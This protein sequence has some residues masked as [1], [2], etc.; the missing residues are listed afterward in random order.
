MHTK[1]WRPAAVAALAVAVTVVLAGLTPPARAA[2]G[3]TRSPASAAIPALAHVQLCA[4]R[5]A[6][7]AARLVVALHGCTQSAPT[8]TATPAGRSS[9]TDTAAPWCC[10]SR[11]ANNPLSCFNWFAAG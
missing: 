10:R 11:P 3:L 7:R 1:F 5:S 6:R 9:P 8:T 2:A 4:G